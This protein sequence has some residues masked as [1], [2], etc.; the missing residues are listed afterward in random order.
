MGVSLVSLFF[1]LL[2]VVGVFSPLFGNLSS[3]K[4][5]SHV[6]CLENEI[7]RF[8]EKRTVI[9]HNCFLCYMPLQISLFLTILIETSILH[10]L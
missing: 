5:I 4:Y 2:T 10:L 6:N 7:V 8:A 3:F 9:P 1:Q